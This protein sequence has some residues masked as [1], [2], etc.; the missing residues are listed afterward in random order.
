MKFPESNGMFSKVRDLPKMGGLAL[1]QNG[2][3]VIQALGLAEQT[4]ANAMWRLGV[5]SGGFTFMSWIGLA[6]QH[7]LPKW[8]R[9]WSVYRQQKQS[10]GAFS[11]QS[12]SEFSSE[13]RTVK[14]PAMA[15]MF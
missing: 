12:A 4:Y 7:W 2:D 8:R 10:K 15:T 5:L 14:V 13:E 1:V 3:Q 6:A 11:Q 9:R